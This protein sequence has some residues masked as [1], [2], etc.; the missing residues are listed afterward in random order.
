MTRRSYV[1]TLLVGLVAAVPAGTAQTDGADRIDDVRTTMDKWVQTRRLIS[2][3]RQDWTLGREMLDER[4]KLVEREIA[5]LREKIAQAQKNIDETDIKR[6]ELV[7]END[8]LKSAGAE[9]AGIVTGMEAQTKALTKRLPD[10]IRSRVKPLSQGLPV[11]PNQTEVSLSR[12]YLNVLG[13][14]LEVNKFNRGIE[15]T[16]EVRTL[17]DGSVAEVTAL[18]LG[19]GQAYYTGGNGTIAGVGRPDADGWTWEPVND[20]AEQVAEAVAILKNE[21][22]AG[23]VPLPLTVQQG[24][25][26]GR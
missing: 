13:I 10:P 17:P 15:L 8:K 23:F 11:D 19:L 22:V 25:G 14:L 20:A 7:A 5:S 4:I 24:A 16:S 26:D 6:A 18:Y 9:L 1:L 3:E 12:R 2:K 21:K